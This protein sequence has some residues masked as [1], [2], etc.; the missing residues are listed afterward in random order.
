MIARR[1]RH[2]AWLA[3]WLL[4]SSLPACTDEDRRAGDRSRGDAAIRAYGC[5][6]C[7]VIPDVPGAVGNV[8]PSLERFHRRVYIAGFIPNT[9]DALAQW[10]EDPQR[11]APDTAMP[12]LGVTAADARLIARH[13]SRD[14]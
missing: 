5:G 9:P 12:N 10:I 11:F 1:Y 8:G 14:E 6:T 7:H 13:L 4:S 2:L 3:A